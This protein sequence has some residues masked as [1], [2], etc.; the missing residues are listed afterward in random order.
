MRTGVVVSADGKGQ[1]DTLCNAL[2][3]VVDADDGQAVGKNADDEYA[4]KQVIDVALAAAHR[5]TA[6]DAGGQRLALVLGTGRRRAGTKTAAENEARNAAQ[7]G[8]DDVSSDI[9]HVGVEAS[10]TGSLGVGAGRVDVAADVGK[11]EDDARDDD[12]HAEDDNGHRDLADVALADPVD[13]LVD[14]GDRLCVGDQV[15][16]ALENRGR[17]HGRNQS[18]HIGLDDKQAVG[19][20]DD[21][22]VVAEVSGL[23][24]D[25]GILSRRTIL[26]RYFGLNDDQAD[27][28]LERIKQESTG[29]GFGNDSTRKD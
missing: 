19:R 8:G 29:G 21:D 12:D 28:E 27:A 16:D 17:R 15:V 10:Q 11:A 14:L 25:S 18:R 7:T 24:V 4:D 22:K 2:P 6:D 1:D 13:G 5:N 26:S 3:V 23:L 20:A 9:H